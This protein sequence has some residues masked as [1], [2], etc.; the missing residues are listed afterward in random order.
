MAVG[1]GGI[2]RGPVR[3]EFGRKT[4]HSQVRFRRLLCDFSDILGITR[5]FFRRNSGYNF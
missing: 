4:A 5:R 3:A 2:G 1:N